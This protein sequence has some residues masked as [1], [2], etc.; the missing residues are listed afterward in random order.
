MNIRGVDPM[1][2]EEIKNRGEEDYN[3]QKIS[4]LEM[5]ILKPHREN[6]GITDLTE[7]EIK[8]YLEIDI[9]ILEKIEQENEENSKKVGLSEKLIRICE[10]TQRYIKENLEDIL[11]VI[12]QKNVETKKE[13]NQ[14][15]QER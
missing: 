13:A 10:E 3:A 5:L 14:N 8:E 7:E 2:Q 9:E 1:S 6:I 4:D 12:R 11:T 15:E